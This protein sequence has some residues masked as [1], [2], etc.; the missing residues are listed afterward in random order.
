MRP[1]F[2]MVLARQRRQLTNARSSRGTDS[3]GCSRESPAMDS[4]ARH[5]WR[6]AEHPRAR[7]IGR[8]AGE[9]VDCGWELT[10]ADNAAIWAR[11][12]LAAKNRLAAADAKLV[13]DA[14]EHRLSELAPS[15][16]AEPQPM[17]PQLLVLSVLASMR[18]VRRETTTSISPTASTRAC[19]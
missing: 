1:I 2:V 18:C 8:V 13:E 9:T 16:T 12:A 19:S 14:F 4:V 15:A 6:A 5:A 3:L 17:L 7:A 11:E 10:S